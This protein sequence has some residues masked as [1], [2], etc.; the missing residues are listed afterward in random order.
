[1]RAAAIALGPAAC[2]APAG[3]PLRAPFGIAVARRRFPAALTAASWQPNSTRARLKPHCAS[4]LCFL[5]WFE[6]G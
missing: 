3:A 1:L 4:R 5:D 6:E 2:A